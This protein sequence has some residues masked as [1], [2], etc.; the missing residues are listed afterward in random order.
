MNILLAT[1][2]D[3]AQRMGGDRVVIENVQAALRSLGH[4]AT[5]SSEAAPDLTGI[6]L[7]HL[8]SLDALPWTY[9]QARAARTGRRPYIITPFYWTSTEAVPVAAYPIAERLV[10]RSLPEG[11]IDAMALRRGARRAGLNDSA[12]NALPHFDRQR[13]RAEVLEGARCIVAS[14][15]AEKD[16]IL[17]DFPGLDP[18]KILPLPF[19]CSLPTPVTP[20]VPPPAPGYFLCVG[21]IG[22][23]KNQLAL[24]RAVRRI[25]GGRLVCIGD[26]AAGAAQYMR[27]VARAAPEDTVFLPAQPHGALGAFYTSARAV[28]Q[29]SFIELPGLVALEAALAGHPVVASDRPPV[30]EYLEGLA[31]FVDPISP[32]AIQ[33]GCETAVPPSASL[34]AE[35]RQRFTWSSHAERLVEHATASLPSPRPARSPSH[36]E[37][38]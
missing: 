21:A 15:Q 36:V 17:R 25:P 5:L 12:L 20:S 18:A 29:P 4:H 2:A 11:W 1:R 26:V 19:G 10:R 38:P 34:A 32:D 35:A 3:H 8:F 6:D 37:A 13:L 16:R 30:R 22:P 33:R 28:V 24:A 7:V 14:G 9:L 23:R 27:A 31:T